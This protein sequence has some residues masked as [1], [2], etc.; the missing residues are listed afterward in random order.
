MQHQDHAY[1]KVRP[2]ENHVLKKIQELKYKML[3]K[4]PN[5]KAN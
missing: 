3:N 5:V 2:F 4:D 1:E